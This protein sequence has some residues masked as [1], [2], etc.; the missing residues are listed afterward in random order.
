ME[1]MKAH[2][3]GKEGDQKVQLSK[4]LITLSPMY[5]CLLDFLHVLL[6]P[7]ALSSE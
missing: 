1:E 4:V 5:S 6:V 7:S 3:L 2:V